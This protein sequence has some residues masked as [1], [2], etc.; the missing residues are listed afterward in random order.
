MTKRVQRLATAASVLLGM[1]AAMAAEYTFK[2]GGTASSPTTGNWSTAGAWVD[3]VAPVSNQDN[4]FNFGGS[5]SGAYTATNNLGNGFQL[6]RIV[7]NSS[8]TAIDAITISS[9]SLSFVNDSSAVA[10]SIVQNGSGGLRFSNAV[11]LTNNLT[12]S[13]SGTGKVDFPAAVSGGGKLIM[14]GAGTVYLRTDNSFTGGVTINSGTVSAGYGNTNRLGSGPVVLN[15]GTLELMNAAGT[16]GV[17]GTTVTANSTILSGNG[18]NPVNSLSNTLSIGDHQLTLGVGTNVSSG[19]ATTRLATASL[20]GN[21]T[22]NVL[23]GAKL[24]VTSLNAGTSRSLNL[25][26]P[27]DIQFTGSTG[28]SATITKNTAGLLSFVG[29]SGLSGTLAVNAGKVDVYNG[30][31]NRLGSL[32][33]TM[34]DNTS[35]AFLWSQN[36]NFANSSAI[37]IAGD[38]TL[39]SDRTTAGAGVT[40]TYGG[41]LSIGPHTLTVSKGANVTS[42]TAT[43]AT[44]NNVTLTGAATIDVTADTVADLRITGAHGLDKT[45]VGTLIL[46]NS[47]YA[48]PVTIGGGQI[49]SIGNHSLSDS[50]QVTAAAGGTMN[51]STYSDT[52]GKVTLAGGTLT[53]T[54]T[55]SAGQPY[56]LHSGTL[57]IAL[58][59]GQPVVKS[60]AGTVNLTRNQSGLN[61]TVNGGTLLVNAAGVGNVTVNDGILGGNGTVAGRATITA[62]AILSP[63][64]SSGT[65][66]VGE[67]E[68]LSGSVFAIELL[69][70]QAGSGYDQVVV[71]GNYVNIEPGAILDVVLGFKAKRGDTFLIVDNQ[72]GDADFGGVFTYGSTVLT[73]GATFAV[74]AYLFDITYAHGGDSIL[75]TVLVPEPASAL[76]LG[77]AGLLA[78]RRRR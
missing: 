72:G 2:G 49:L 5:G 37:N 74:G 68:L 52:I 13:G 34:N 7:A 73:E 40:T 3:G 76:L 30:N 4:V 25:T 41:T 12:L 14:S 39:Y 9:N 20:T 43:L 64:N 21:A 48:G 35:M 19:T 27:G 16:F 78:L 53:G 46:R 54:G 70:S 44:A 32:A 71:T 1:G 8:S 26:G 59:S 77:A 17:S 6:N 66:T 10:P 18:A 45:G 65:L 56:A 69:G 33:V 24:T 23:S 75:L 22:F 61:L 62:D 60:T 55:L 47:S 29:D 15:G 67:L 42:G 28:S 38:L 31:A 63:G 11:V 51:L 58:G 36:V 57:D 50:L